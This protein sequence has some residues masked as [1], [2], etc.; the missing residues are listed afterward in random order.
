[1]ISSVLFW[2]VFVRTIFSQRKDGKHSG[3]KNKHKGFTDV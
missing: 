1:M 2:Y 3:K